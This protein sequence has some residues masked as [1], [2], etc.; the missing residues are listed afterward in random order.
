M[1]FFFKQKTAYEME[2][3]VLACKFGS[4][5]TDGFNP[6]DS[7]CLNNTTIYPDHVPIMINTNI[8]DKNGKEIYE[9]DIVL[10]GEN[11]YPRVIEYHIFG[12]RVKQINSENNFPLYY[13]FIGKNG[14]DTDWEIIG[15]IH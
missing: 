7:A 13:P 9:G 12:L 11:K 3:N 8:M 10:L 15:N 14:L 2:Y 5:Y 1:L 6:S 4:F